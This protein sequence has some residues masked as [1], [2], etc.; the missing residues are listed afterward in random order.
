MSIQRLGPDNFE[1]FT[2]E[3][4]SA[5]T[6]TSASAFSVVNKEG[7][8]G[9]VSVFPRG[10]TIEKDFDSV[11]AFSDLSTGANPFVADTFLIKV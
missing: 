4:H 11:G 8:T 2:L 3:L 1:Q 5:K 9:S 7:I 10:S 6:Y